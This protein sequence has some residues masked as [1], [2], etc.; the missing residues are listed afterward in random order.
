[1]KNFKLLIIIVLALISVNCI[2]IGILWYNNYSRRPQPVTGNAFEYLTKELSLTPA[3]LKQ[4]DILRKQHFEFTRQMGEQQ[5]A[6]RDSFFNNLKL[7]TVDTAAQNALEERIL[8]H[9]HMLD[10]ATFNHFR[11]VRAILTPQQQTRFDDLIQDVLRMMGQPHPPGRDP[12]P[13]Q[14]PPAGLQG[15]AQ[16]GPPPI[17]GQFNGRH[18]RPG[19]GRLQGGPP[20]QGPQ[21]QGPPPM[22]PPQ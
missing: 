16:Q 18:R 4:Y 21:P 9:Q 6:M 13:E 10:T 3:Q 1:M 7:T 14:R 2:L 19:M 20:P 15:E 17:R 22:G 5:R 8:Q 12:R 11:K